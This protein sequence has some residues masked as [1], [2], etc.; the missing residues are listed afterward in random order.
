VLAGSADLAGVLMRDSFSGLDFLAG[1]TP[2]AGA[3]ALN[4][5]SS[6]ELTGLIEKVRSVYDVVI[7]D[8][9]P[10]LPVA[11]PR[12]LVGQV[13][14]VALVVASELTARSAVQA[15]LQETPGI[16]TK[17]LGAVMNR[18]VDDYGRNYAEYGSFYKVA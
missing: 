14:G 13:D 7:V 4:L 2:L 16:E 17:I 10:L 15:A 8:S 5:L 3:E 18:V 12:V 1:D 6:R 11:D 9:A